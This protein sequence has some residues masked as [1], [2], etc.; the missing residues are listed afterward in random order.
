MNRWFDELLKDSQCVLNK[1]QF[2]FL[3]RK[4]MEKITTIERKG[5]WEK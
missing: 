5:E 2:I 4:N 3:K 1:F